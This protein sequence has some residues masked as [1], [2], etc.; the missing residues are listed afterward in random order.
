MTTGA[1]PPVDPL[2]VAMAPRPPPGRDPRRPDATPSVVNPWAANPLATGE[3]AHAVD[4][5][6]AADGGPSD[7]ELEKILEQ[8]R[9]LGYLEA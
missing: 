7:A 2:R 3:A 8:M 4:R 6:A 9:A 5:D 1:A